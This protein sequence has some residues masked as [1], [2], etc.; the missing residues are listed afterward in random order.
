MLRLA[1]LSAVGALALA[2]TAGATTEPTL[3]VGVKVSLGAQAVALSP[4]RV[5]RGMYVQ[6]AVR[7]ATRARHVF[8]VAGRSIVVPA[9]RRRLL[10]LFFDAR[11]RYRY[12]S[13]G[14]GMTV[15]GVFVVN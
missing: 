3:I 11:G 4:N 9:L 1:L 6:F 14:G 5:N 8:S 15:H 12:V 7:N 2:A 10:V 13:R